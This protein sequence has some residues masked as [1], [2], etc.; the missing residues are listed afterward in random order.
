MQLLE[1][2]PN[3]AEVLAACR[4]PIKIQAA[5]ATDSR[6]N[7]RPIPAANQPRKTPSIPNPHP[8]IF[9]GG[10]GN[11]GHLVT[12]CES[13]SCHAHTENNQWALRQRAN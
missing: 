1:R 8:P 5:P 4:V 11:P 6:I 2:K 3:E 7:C 10:G 12:R 13:A 9:L